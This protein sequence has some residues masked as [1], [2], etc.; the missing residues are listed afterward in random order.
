M[1]KKLYFSLNFSTKTYFDWDIRANPPLEKKKSQVLEENKQPEKLK[2][3]NDRK[4]EMS[5]K[6]IESQKNMQNRFSSENLSCPLFTEREIPNEQITAARLP[7]SQPCNMNNVKEIDIQNSNADFSC[8]QM[9]Y[10]INK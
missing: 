5:D 8:L 9:S 3:G 2:D 1:F 4:E 10:Y 7:Y 6:L